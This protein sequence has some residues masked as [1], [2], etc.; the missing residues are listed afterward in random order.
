L[1]SREKFCLI[2]NFK[3]GGEASAK[4]DTNGEDDED[5]VPGTF[6]VWLHLEDSFPEADAL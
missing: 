5:L 6:Y 4:A 2:S 1:Y 3:C